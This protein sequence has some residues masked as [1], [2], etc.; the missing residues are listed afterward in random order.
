MTALA[1]ALGLFALVAVAVLISIA[2]YNWPE[3]AANDDFLWV[4]P[5]PP[6]AHPTPGITR[7]T[8]F[9]D[10]GKVLLCSCVS[11]FPEQRDH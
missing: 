11:S 10:P 1:V 2:G 8:V 6:P 5:I 4:V 9:S 7:L 3:E